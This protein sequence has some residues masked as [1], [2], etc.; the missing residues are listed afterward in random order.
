MELIKEINKAENRIPSWK[1][2]LGHFKLPEAHHIILSRGNDISTNESNFKSHYENLKKQYQRR[3]LIR[4]SNE[5]AILIAAK[6]IPINILEK[7]QAK[8]DKLRE[9]IGETDKIEIYDLLVDE[10]KL[11]TEILEG[12]GI[13]TIPTGFQGFDKEGKGIPLDALVTVAAP[14]G[15]GKS[16]FA[17]AMAQK[18]IKPW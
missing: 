5:L 4:L 13:P 12:G 18:P 17:Q 1:E 16:M 8:I 15:D 11:E 6:E 3:E 7:H 14:T 2:L 9:K 10:E